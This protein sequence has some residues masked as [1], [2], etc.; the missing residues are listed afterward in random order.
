[1]RASHHPRTTPACI[2]STIKSPLTQE[3]TFERGDFLVAMR[4]YYIYH[5]KIPVCTGMTKRHKE[6]LLLPTIVGLAMT[7]PFTSLRT[8]AC[9]EP[10]YRE[11]ACS[12]FIEASNYRRAL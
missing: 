12:D 5:N 1:L 6:R 2:K 10:I 11:L 7:R 9:P 4:V 3:L 8:A